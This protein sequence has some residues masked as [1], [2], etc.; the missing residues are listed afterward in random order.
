MTHKSGNGLTDYQ[1]A[2]DL[3]PHSWIVECLKMFGIA[4][5]VKKY[6]FIV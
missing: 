3:L 1:K 5:N 6:I 4:E 2:Y